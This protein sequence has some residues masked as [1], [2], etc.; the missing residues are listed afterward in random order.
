MAS[1][2]TNKNKKWTPLLKT[3][4]S[5][6]ETLSLGPKRFLHSKGPKHAFCLWLR[7]RK[8]EQCRICTVM[9]C[10]L[11]LSLSQRQNAFLGPL[12]WRDLF[13]PKNKVSSHEKL[14]FRSG[15][16]FL[17]LFVLM[18]AILVK[19]D[20]QEMRPTNDLIN[21]CF[22]DHWWFRSTPS[23]SCFWSLNFN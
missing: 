9:R 3:N 19:L 17:F 13:G 14:V 4:F 16:R 10:S 1:I 23:K 8:S 22:K 18:D 7:L 15:V 2:K 5:W 6:L 12:E 20:L 11:F 21:W